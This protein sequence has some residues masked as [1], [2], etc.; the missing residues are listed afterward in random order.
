MNLDYQRFTKN[1]DDKYGWNDPFLTTRTLSQ[2]DSVISSQEKRAS[3]RLHL[4]CAA[5]EIIIRSFSWSL[6]YNVLTS[7]KTRTHITTYLYP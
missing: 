3:Q 7:Q 5:R 1:I 6:P 2:P 4:S